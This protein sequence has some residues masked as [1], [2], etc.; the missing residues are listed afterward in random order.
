LTLPEPVDT[1]VRFGR[2]RG[3]A[4]VMELRR[5]WLVLLALAIALATS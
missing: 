2:A 4:T 1:V 5:W 3:E